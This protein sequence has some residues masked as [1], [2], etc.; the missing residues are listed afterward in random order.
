MNKY[1]STFT[2]KNILLDEV[3]TGDFH[4]SCYLF[5]STYIHS[6]M[7]MN[8]KGGKWK[9]NYATSPRRHIRRVQLFGW[10]A[11]QRKIKGRKQ[12]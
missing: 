7:T 10:M 5:P 3:T 2:L 6:G 9:R 12:D 4:C 11:G 8:G 1:M